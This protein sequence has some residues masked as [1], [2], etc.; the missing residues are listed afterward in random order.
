MKLYKKNETN[1]NEIIY[2]PYYIHRTNIIDKSLK[3]PKIV[4]KKL[5]KQ[6]NTEE[7][8][9]DNCIISSEFKYI[10]KQYL[11]IK[12]HQNAENIDLNKIIINLAKEYK[13]KKL[14]NSYLVY[15]FNTV[16]YFINKWI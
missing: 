1:N 5:E 8:L 6:V 10:N 15:M 11:L 12:I 9:S 4:L 13:P 16:K 2:T 7:S 14:S 3:N